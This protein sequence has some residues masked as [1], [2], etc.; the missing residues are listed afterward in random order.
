[1]IGRLLGL[2]DRYA[3]SATWCILGHLLLD[4]CT[5]VNGRKHPEIVPPHHSWMQG[6]W[7]ADDPCTSEQVDPIYYGRS[8]VTRIRD[9]ATPQEIG[10]H[11]FSHVIFGDPGCSRET[12]VS[13][14][15]ACG[16]LADELGITLRSFAF[17][18]NR[19]GHLEV[20]RE[21]GIVCFRGPEPNW[22]ERLAGPAAVK[23]A[24]HLLDVILARTPP[25]GLPIQVLPGL[26][27]IPGSMI[28]FPSHGPRRYIAMSQRVRR[29]TR[30]LDRAERERRII[31]LWFH[32]TNLADH[33]DAM[34][35]G[36]ERILADAAG[37][38]DAGRLEIRT[39]SELVSAGSK[40]V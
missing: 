39:M 21:H 24:G 10:C 3:I 40:L 15:Q 35:A 14:L 33:T 26:W 7:F 19:V 17:P 27:N 23:R 1:M 18:R 36:L 22:H 37:R 8:L 38:R 34:F 12:A 2:L 16:R 20:L 6:D 9:C 11:S 5:P 13:E 29:A 4:H 30:G 25:V 28:F 31:H 32:P